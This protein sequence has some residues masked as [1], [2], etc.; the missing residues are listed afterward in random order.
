MKKK[1]VWRSHDITSRGKNVKFISKSWMWVYKCDASESSSKWTLH[2][3]KK[4]KAKLQ[5]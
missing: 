3:K 1:C 5:W 2:S 4:A